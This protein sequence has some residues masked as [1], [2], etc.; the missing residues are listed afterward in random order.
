MEG[1]EYFP[2]QPTMECPYRLRNGGCHEDTHHQF[3]P[4][5]QYHGTLE[6]TFK[7]LPRF[8]IE[9]CRRLHDDIHATEPTPV[10]PDRDYMRA[11]IIEADMAGEVCLSVNKRKAVYGRRH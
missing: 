3:Y 7:N 6:R 5:N 10:K 2:C 11:Q 4:D 9:V 1:A 8:M